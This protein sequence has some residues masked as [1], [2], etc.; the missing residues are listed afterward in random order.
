M[1]EYVPAIIDNEIKK[2]QADFYLASQKAD[3]K[4]L[5]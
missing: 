3:A 5:P 1:A 4:A 2:V